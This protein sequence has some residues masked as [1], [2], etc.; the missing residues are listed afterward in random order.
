MNEYFD[1]FLNF[2]LKV[3]AA[4]DAGL[5]TL[6]SFKNELKG[7]RD[8][9]A[10]SYLTDNDAL[11]RLIK[12]AYDRTVNEVS[13]SHIMIRLP[14]NPTSA[15]TLKAYQKIMDIRKKIIAG[16]SF[17]KMAE[18]Y[19]ED[20]STK[21]YK[22]KIG[23]FT[24]FRIVYPFESVAFNTKEGEVSMPLRTKFGYHLIKVNKKRP[25]PGEVKVAH[26]MIVVP[27]IRPIASGT[28]QKIK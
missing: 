6:T 19:T 10:K 3:S 16:Q 1:L 23:Y 26:I 22:G 25:S 5:D 18:E 20:L 9:L 24:A 13:A 11:D 7:Y 14:E 8:Q 21:P 4:L 2:E 28:W 12:E 17:E 15:D 27:R